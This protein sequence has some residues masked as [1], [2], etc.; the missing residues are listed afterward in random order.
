VTLVDTPGVGGFDGTHDRATIAALRNATALLFCADGTRPL[1]EPELAFLAEASGSIAHVV[2]VL[3]KTDQQPEWRTILAE[4][5]AAVLRRAPI[6]DGAPWFPVAAPLAE[7]SLD[8]ALPVEA[9]RVLRQR[10]GLDA[11]REH[12]VDEIAN[13]V[14]ILVA[15]NTVKQLRADA[16]AVREAAVAR[17]EMLRDPSVDNRQRLVD[18]QRELERLASVEDTWRTDLDLALTTLRAAELN[19]M[20]RFLREVG[21]LGTEQAKRRDLPAE[22][23]AALVNERLSAEAGQCLARIVSGTAQQIESIVGDATDTP[24][25]AAALERAASSADVVDLR[26]GKELVAEGRLQPAQAMPLTMTVTTG[27]VAA[28]MLPF[29]VIP[30]VGVGL[31]IAAAGAAILFARRQSRQNERTQW[32]QA[33]LSEAR[34]DLTTMID[35]RISGAKTLAQRAVREWIR[36][37]QSQLRAGIAELNAQMNRDAKAQQEAVRAARAVVE[38]ADTQLRTCDSYLSTLTYGR[39]P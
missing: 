17:V 14:Q 38:A 36:S 6:F 2:F 10:S 8:P 23:L 5:R 22:G 33:R 7:K 12:L 26:E 3:T 4:N 15:A 32:V 27:L 9:A 35:Q 34:T 37:R 18:E 21:D 25:F 31:G 19:A 28:K 16:H 13:R 29:T 11:V 20:D 39:T 24:A 30:V 1:S